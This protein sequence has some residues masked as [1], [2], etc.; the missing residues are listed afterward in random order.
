MKDL[1]KYLYNK[2]K[3]HKNN[4]QYCRRCGR[5]LKTKES[6]SLGLGKCCYEKE[7]RTKYSKQLF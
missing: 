4:Y 5:R 2:L 7:V 3:P 1:I 6:R